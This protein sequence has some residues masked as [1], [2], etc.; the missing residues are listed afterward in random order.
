[1]AAIVNV[2]VFD[3]H[4]YRTGGMANRWMEKMVQEFVVHAKTRCPTR[5]RNMQNRIRGGSQRVGERQLEGRITSGARYTTFVI[6]GT[7]GPIYP[8]NSRKLRVPR[9]KGPLRG[10]ALPMSRVRLRPSVAGQKAN[11]FLG[12]AWRDTARKHSSIRGKTMPPL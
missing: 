6:N 1:M 4:I 10:S 11:N 8:E 9:V 5:T 3:R 7:T 12:Q 2:V